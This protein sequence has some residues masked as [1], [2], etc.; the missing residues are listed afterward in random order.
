MRTIRILLTGGGSGGHVYP[1]LSVAESLQSVAHSPHTEYEIHY[2]G[3]SDIYSAKLAEAGIV[4]HK[5]T[6][7]KIRRYA[8]G[9]LANIFDLPRFIFGLLQAFV[10]MFWLMPDVIFS[11]GGPGAYPVVLAGW[12]YRIPVMIHDSDAT[13]G[14]TNLL[15]ARFSRRI[16]VSF[17]RAAKYFNPKKTIVTGS[18]LRRALLES[19]PDSAR[20]KED[21]G[22]DPTLALVVVL[23]GSQGSQRIN[24]FVALNLL[25]LI[26][27]VQIYHQA[28]SASYLDIK[29]ITQAELLGV[30]IAEELHTRYQLLPY[31]DD[32]KTV[33][34]AADLVVS[35]AGSGSIFEIASFGKPSI[36]I[37]LHESANDHQ[38]TNA[39]E[40][41]RLGAAVVIEESNFQP[42]IFLNQIRDILTHPETV[43]KMSAA[44]SA[45]F[46]P[47]AEEEIAKELLILAG[48]GQK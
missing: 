24:E 45:F 23:G 12:F 14:L 26:K 35:R 22:F 40:Y 25:E 32:M 29:K 15:S 17:D 16:A 4:L 34:A 18:P 27:D 9:I 41:A 48:E 19:R 7:S 36:L 10:K 30:S 1:L 13:P 11:K 8:S 21:L 39:Y 20:A 5:I 44:A 47:G 33:L 37:P 3:P 38:R 6:S 2:F 42:A 43:Q 31:V 46:H 28:G